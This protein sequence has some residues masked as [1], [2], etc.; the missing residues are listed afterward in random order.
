ML[1]S[2]D[3]V[4]V[5]TWT[6]KSGMAGASSAVRGKFGSAVNSQLIKNTK[7]SDEGPSSSTNGFVAGA[8]AGRAL[9]SAELLAKIRGNQERAVETGI[10]HQ[11]NIAKFF[12][13]GTSRTAQ[14][15][16][17]VQPEV[18]I[19]QICTF[20]QQR[21]GSTD[22][23]SIVQ[24]FKDRIPSKDLPLFKNLLKEIAKLEK[25]QNGAVW[26]S[27]NLLVPLSTVAF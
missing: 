16:G 10:E 17:R 27:D 25:N 18:V 4:S 15:L 23:S 26:S 9:S 20:I 1:Q 22:S 24:H 5:P 7:R 21:G 6:G 13:V 3:G 14:N 8:P 2:C 19:R 12:D 11:F